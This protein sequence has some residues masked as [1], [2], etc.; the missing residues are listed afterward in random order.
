MSEKETVPYYCRNC[1]K[2]VKCNVSVWLEKI[3]LTTPFYR[4]AV[5][6]DARCSDCGAILASGREVIELY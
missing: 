5:Q 2:D 4:I 6:A 3:V 1:K